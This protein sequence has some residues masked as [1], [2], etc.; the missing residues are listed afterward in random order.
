MDN[1]DSLIEVDF[2]QV[3]TIL[4]DCP[5]PRLAP[6]LFVCEKGPEIVT[7]VMCSTPGPMFVRVTV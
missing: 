1:E 7:L 5:A 3:T 6:Q 4:Q 2:P